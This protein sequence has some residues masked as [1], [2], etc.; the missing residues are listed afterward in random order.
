VV[1]LVEFV[2]HHSNRKLQESGGSGGGS[3]G[4][5]VGHMVHNNK[6]KINLCR[7]LQ[8]RGNCPRGTNCTFAHSEEELE[9]YRSKIKKHPPRCMS[10]TAAVGGKDF[11]NYDMTGGGVGLD[12][13]LL[14][15]P[16]VSC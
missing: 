10:A 14:I 11:N 5:G 12:N 1:G 6:Y 9:K 15:P 4:G 2:Q 3:G 7:D 16:T 13:L 8:T